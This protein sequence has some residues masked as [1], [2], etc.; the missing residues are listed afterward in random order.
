MSF[1]CLC[2]FSRII[3]VVCMYSTYGR[4]AHRKV[5][6]VDTEGRV[7]KGDVGIGRRLLKCMLRNWFEG[8]D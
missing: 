2:E 1:G 8:M 6:I 5:C 7:N 4:Q 3:L